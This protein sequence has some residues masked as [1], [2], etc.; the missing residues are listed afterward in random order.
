[1]L[2]L[3]IHCCIFNCSET[4]VTVISVAGTRKFQYVILKIS[5][6][7]RKSVF[8]L[9]THRKEVLIEIIEPRISLCIKNLNSFFSREGVSGEE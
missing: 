6:C 3:F 5:S 8:A 7:V 9:R 2:Q 1:M 4:Y